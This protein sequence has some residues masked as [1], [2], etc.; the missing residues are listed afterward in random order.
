MDVCSKSA[1]YSLSPVLQ[2]LSFNYNS[3]LPNP[4]HT[5]KTTQQIPQNHREIGLPFEPIAGGRIKAKPEITA[6]M[7]K[8]TISAPQLYFPSY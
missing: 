1:V 5:E 7:R 2:T 4:Q 6:M 8:S 3:L